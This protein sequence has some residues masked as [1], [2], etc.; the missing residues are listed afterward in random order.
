[1][2]DAVLYD[3][4]RSSASWR[5]RI[6]LTLSGIDW[7]CRPVDLMAGDQRSAAHLA[8]NPQGLVPVLEIDGLRLTQSLAILEYLEETGR[9]SLR[10]EA[11]AQAARM[12]AIA[13]AIACDV[14]PVCN[15]RVA[16]H[17]AALT[18]RDDTRADWM[19]HFIRPGLE[20]VEAMLDETG[21]YC[22]GAALTQADLCLIPQLYN[23]ARWGVETSDLTRITRVARACAEL[24][25]FRRAAPEARLPAAV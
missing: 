7:E 24:D 6:A 19:R 15:L 12:R 5:V 10:P 3:Y 13:L 17:A 4:W 14:H 8:R 21:P 2:A 11:P 23:A 16:A 20:A 1:M 22:M 9:L 25:A 18:G